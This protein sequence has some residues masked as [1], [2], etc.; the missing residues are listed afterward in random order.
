MLLLYGITA[1][2]CCA[3]SDEGVQGLF[4]KRKAINLVVGSIPSML[5]GSMGRLEVLQMKTMIYPLLNSL[6]RR[7]KKGM[8][9]TVFISIGFESKRQIEN[10]TLWA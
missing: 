9:Y 5:D 4:E 1:S 2:N 10:H 7:F 8:E 6:D 3:I